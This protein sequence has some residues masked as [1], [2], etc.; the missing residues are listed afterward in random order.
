MRWVGAVAKAA[1]GLPHLS[2]KKGEC[3]SLLTVFADCDLR[4]WS[5]SQV[6]CFGLRVCVF[7]T[8][9]LV[10]MYIYISDDIHIYIYIWFLSWDVCDWVLWH[11]VIKSVTLS[12]GF[13][14]RWWLVGFCVFGNKGYQVRGCK[15]SMEG[16]AGRSYHP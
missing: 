10:Y 1:A 6:R 13:L 15:E 9:C 11:V 2:R 8:A 12:A 3:A 4:F 7:T 5:F 14:V 16:F